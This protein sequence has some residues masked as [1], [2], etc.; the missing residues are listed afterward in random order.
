MKGGLVEKRKYSRVAT[1]PSSISEGIS[2]GHPLIIDVSH[3]GGRAYGS[4]IPL[5]KSKVWRFSFGSM[6]MIVF[7]NPE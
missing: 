5:Q 6:G 3:G 7:C 1:P 2:L 4:A